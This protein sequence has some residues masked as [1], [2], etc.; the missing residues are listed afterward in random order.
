MLFTTIMEIHK[1]FQEATIFKN[2]S[3]SP[4]SPSWDTWETS[5]REIGRP[6]YTSLWS[7]HAITT[8]SAEH[9][10]PRRSHSF[11]IT[12]LWE[13]LL[14]YELLLFSW[15][16]ISCPSNYYP[17]LGEEYHALQVNFNM[18]STTIIEIPKHLQ[19]T[20]TF[21]NYVFM[22]KTPFWP[23]S[24]LFRYHG[25]ERYHSS[26]GEKSP[27]LRVTHRKARW[28]VNLVPA[29]DFVKQEPQNPSQAQI[30]RE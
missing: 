9:Q 14:L 17:S 26:L 6:A 24:L 5:E 18:F 13:N 21:E 22:V 23:A 27:G 3:R 4:R 1:H 15:R 29:R 10:Y 20:M 16:G 7:P 2:K 11:G 28:T 8:Q 19:K 30:F 12:L 25:D